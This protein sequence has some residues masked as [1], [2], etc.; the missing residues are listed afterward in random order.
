M[1]MDASDEDLQRV[2]PASY[3][4]DIIAPVSIHH[5]IDDATV[6]YEWSEELAARME[7]LDKPVELFLYRNTPHTF[8]DEADRLFIARMIAFFDAHLR[9]EE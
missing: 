6:P 1:E 2:S 9:P 5:S 7:A 8:R 3:L 4:Q